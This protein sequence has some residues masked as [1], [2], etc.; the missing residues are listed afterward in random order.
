MDAN[1]ILDEARVS[2]VRTAQADARLASDEAYAHIFGGGEGSPLR[3]AWEADRNLL[4]G[5]HTVADLEVPFGVRRIGNRA[6]YNPYSVKTLHIPSSV[7]VIG[8]EAFYSCTNLIALT[9]DNGCEK[10][11]DKAFYYMQKLETLYLP[12]SLKTIGQYAF[13]YCTG[14]TTLEIGSGI[15]SIGVGAFSNIPSSCD[16]T[17]KTTSDKFQSSDL[18]RAGFTTGM[19]IKF[20]DKDVIL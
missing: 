4:T 5:E 10:I 8:V 11:M 3:V 2:L 1:E 12:D 19:T 7:K 6:F 15:T 9:I 20:T 18:T 13:N 16:V 14:L 17:I